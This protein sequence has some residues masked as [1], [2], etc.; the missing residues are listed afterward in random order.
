MGGRARL[1]QG[2]GVSEPIG[3]QSEG[4]VSLSE[5]VAALLLQILDSV[6]LTVTAASIEEQAELIA[7][8]RRELGG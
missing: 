2:L 7:R 3:L 8:A 6:Q 5:D 1:Y 4:G